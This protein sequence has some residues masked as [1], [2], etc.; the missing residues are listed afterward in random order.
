MKVGGLFMYNNKNFIMN[1][2]EKSKI[3][4]KELLEE[5]EKGVLN[6][7]TRADVLH[8]LEQAAKKGMAFECD[9]WLH[10]RQ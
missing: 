9:N 2:S 10:K 7:Y 1:W 5:M 8:G 4:A 6:S 3:I